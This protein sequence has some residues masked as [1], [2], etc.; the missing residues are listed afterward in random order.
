MQLYLRE[1]CK[2]ALATVAPALAR[3]LSGC[4]QPAGRPQVHAVYGAL[5]QADGA[6][7]RQA[8]RRR[9]T[10]LVAAGGVY[11]AK[12]HQGVGWREIAKNLLAG[13]RPVVGAGN[14]FVACQRLRAHGVPAP[15]VA[16]FGTCG[17]N[18]ARQRSFL[19]CDALTGMASVEELASDLAPLLRG[20]LIVA[21]GTLLRAMHGAGVHHRDCY[22]PHLFADAAQWRRGRVALAVID[23]H[24]ARV[25]GRLPSRWRRRDLGAL[26][27]SASALHLTSRERLRFAAAYAGDTKTWRRDRRFWRGV[28]RR[29]QRLQR[30]GVAT[31][32]LAGAAPRAMVP[33]VADFHAFDEQPAAPFRF[34]ANLDSGPT[35]IQCATML[36]WHRKR[37]FTALA[38]IDG[39]EQLLSAFFGRGR[40]RRFRRACRVA[41]RLAAT[42]FGPDTVKTGRCA[43]ALLLACPPPGGR[44]PDAGDLPMLLTMLARLHEQSLC[45]LD[46][47][48]VQFRLRRATAGISAWQVGPLPLRR[49]PVIERDLGV[50]LAR[51]GG[52]MSV[53]EALRLYAQGRRRPAGHLRGDRVRRHMVTEIA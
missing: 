33:S 23:L 16:A 48:R 26:L 35:Q 1:D 37:G 46:P 47:W 4:D 43:G 5:A 52:G 53:A 17:R 38:N 19:V 11:F 2:A 3:A 21:A 32:N 29:A 42:G 8:A 40:A 13:K 49:R 10:R 51:F 39:R 41:R 34:H 12:L 18:P 31:T 15:R 50:L 36:C 45:P 22:L 9:T 25:R 28:L 20:R 44:H 24:R 7:Y 30:R 27:C 14:E 6:V